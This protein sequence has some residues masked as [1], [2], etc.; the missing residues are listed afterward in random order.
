MTAIEIPDIGGTAFAVGTGGAVLGT[1]PTGWSGSVV[2]TATLGGPTLKDG[3]VPTAWLD[4]T[5]SST[6]YG[7]TSAAGVAFTLQSSFSASLAANVGYG[8]SGGVSGTI[9]PPVPGAVPEPAS[10][11][12]LG[13]GLLG[14]FAAWRRKPA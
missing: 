6:T 14:L 11:A 1:L 2:T 9:D 8:F 3:T 7:I 5:A 12:V 4:L 13:V 10:L